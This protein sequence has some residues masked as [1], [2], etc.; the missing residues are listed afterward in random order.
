MNSD[1]LYYYVKEKL[2]VD[3]TLT[4]IDGTNEIT[5]NVHKNI[6]S[7]ACIYFEK[8]LTNFKEKN[9]NNITITVPNTHVSYDIIISFYNIKANIGI[10]ASWKHLLE[11]YKCYDFFGLDIDPKLLFDLEIPAEGFELLLEVIELIGYDEDMIK[12][13]NKNI[14]NEYDLSKLPEELLNNMIEV[15]KSYNIVLSGIYGIKIWDSKTENLV[16]KL[17]GTYVSSACYSAYNKRIISANNHTDIKIW[18]AEMG[19]LLH[20]LVTHDG[21]IMSV[22]YSSDNKRIVSGSCDKSIKIWSTEKGALIT[23]LIGHTDSVMSVCF[24]PDNKRIVSGSY[25]NNIKIWEE[26]TG[27]L[28]HTL[29]GHTDCV[30]S[31]CYSPD[32]KYV[33]SGSRDKSIKIWN[34]ESGQLV[35]TLNGHTGYVKSVCY[36]PNGKCIASGSRDASIKIWNAKT[37]KLIRTLNEDSGFIYD[38][39]I[40]YSWDNKYIVSGIENGNIEIW[41]AETGQFVRRWAG[42]VGHIRSI[43]YSS[44]YDSELT[45]K[46]KK[47][48]S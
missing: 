27:Q 8:L 43:C 35:H 13:I 19:N 26:K 34:A 11:S 17:D 48:L 31:V 37:G 2:F 9:S 42:G 40:C 45:K 30:Y 28:V 18:D 39:C 3:L 1:K 44:N 15:T 41:D 25:D 47:L 36:S 32:N 6:L 33:V 5:I 12:L 4:L 46:I 38:V 16:R 24:S 14:P 21:S 23:T 22:C 10:L 20:T 7:C 29:K